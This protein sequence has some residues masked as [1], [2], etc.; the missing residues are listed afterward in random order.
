VSIMKYL[1]ETN[2]VQ[3]IGLTLIL[4]SLFLG[5][6]SISQ[7]MAVDLYENN[8]V[9][10]T[11]QVFLQ[12]LQVMPTSPSLIQPEIPTSLVDP[13]Q[14]A[15]SQPQITGTPAPTPEGLIPDHITISS[16]H[17]YAPIIQV[18]YSNVTID[19]QDFL[20][21]NVPNERAV[22]WHDTS[23]KLGQV[24]NIVLNGHHNAFGYV[25]AKLVDL[26]EG[27]LIIISSG[28]TEFK[29]KVDKVLVI[30]EEGM[31]IDVRIQNASWIAPT[32][33]ERLTLVSCWPPGDNTHRVIVV[34]IPLGE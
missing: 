30:R 21:W 25:F 15:T 27:D 28:S 16:I 22:G 14:I 18:Q 1:R 7:V 6:M 31:P 20:E 3:R 34:A 17:L 4:V 32:L 13:T 2:L 19:G 12:P 10:F 26:K 11:K 9:D 5:V 24:G 23:A 8:E 29:Y 33:N